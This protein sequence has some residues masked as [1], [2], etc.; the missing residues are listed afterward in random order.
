M[1]FVGKNIVLYIVENAS[2]RSAVSAPVRGPASE[3]CLILVLFGGFIFVAAMIR[4]GSGM[5]IGKLGSAL[6]FF[7]T[8]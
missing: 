1:Y 2:S 5:K 7:A 8:R 6:C 4:N 3:M